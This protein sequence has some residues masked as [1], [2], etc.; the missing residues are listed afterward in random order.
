MQVIGRISSLLWTVSHETPS[1]H[2]ESLTG[3]DVRPK[4]SLP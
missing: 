1:R 4:I 2:N 3:A